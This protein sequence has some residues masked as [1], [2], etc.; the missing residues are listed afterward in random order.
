[1]V[2]SETQTTIKSQIKDKVYPPIRWKGKRKAF[3]LFDKGLRPKDIS[4]RMVTG[5]KRRSLYRYY[6]EWKDMQ[7]AI[8]VLINRY[9]AK[10]IT[11]EAKQEP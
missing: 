2:K 7:R 10:G 6:T 9:V 11:F 4:P 1:M 5:I 3:E 8:P